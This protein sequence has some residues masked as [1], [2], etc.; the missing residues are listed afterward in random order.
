[1][2]DGTVLAPPDIALLRGADQW[3]KVQYMNGFSITGHG[4]FDGQGPTAWKQ[5][6]CAKNEK[7][8]MPTMV[9]K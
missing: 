9:C 8:K 3:I 5:N 2:V 6:D 4:V 7:C 1:M